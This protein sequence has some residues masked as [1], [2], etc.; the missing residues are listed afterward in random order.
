MDALTALQTRTAAPRLVEPA[1]QGAALDAILKA[2]LR[3]P[4]HGMLRPWR[5]L[6]VS[7]DARRKLGELFVEAMQPD[8]EERRKKLLESPLRAPLLIVG[9][10]TPKEKDGVPAIEQINS[11][12][13]AL[14]NMS[15]AI[16]A[17]GFASIWRTGAAAYD[18]K[19]KQALGL[20]SSDAI[21]GYLY[22]GTPTVSERPVPELAIKDYV[23]NWG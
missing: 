2:G 4:D 7:G 12:A 15:V 1:P 20:S 6:V 14:Q 3:A 16:H 17:L 8:T 18:P 23:Q 21:V 11:T 5:F 22:V 10:A 19:V 13:A 9:I